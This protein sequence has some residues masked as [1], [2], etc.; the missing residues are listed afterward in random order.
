VDSQ[1]CS[2]YTTIYYQRN[3]ISIQSVLHTLSDQS[4]A[5]PM[6]S[7]SLPTPATGQ[8]Q[9]IK[10]VNSSANPYDSRERDDVA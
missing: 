5:L 2:E 10:D 7:A 4:S 8:L 3:T 1:E 6:P 9:K